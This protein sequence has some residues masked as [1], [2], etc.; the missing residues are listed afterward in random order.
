MALAL[1]HVYFRAFF[2][3]I[4]VR[5]KAK[6]LRKDLGPN[7]RAA[8]VHMI[9]NLRALGFEFYRKKN[10]RAYAALVHVYINAWS[11]HNRR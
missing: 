4:A 2:V 9:S 1:V 7:L 6:T 10:Q 3:T 11:R 8:L 5:L